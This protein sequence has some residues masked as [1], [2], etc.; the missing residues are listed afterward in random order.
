[1]VLLKDVEYL[2]LTYK[3]PE[4]VG[5][6]ALRY[7]QQQPVIIHLQSVGLYLLRVAE[8]R[9]VERVVVVVY[10][11]V[12]GVHTPLGLQQFHLRL[13]ALFP[14][15]LYYFLGR[16]VMTLNGGGRR[17]DGIHLRAQGVYIVGCD[18]APDAEQTVVAVAHGELNPYLPVREEVVYGLAEDEEQGARI[19]FQ[20]QRVGD[21]DKLHRL[22]GVYAIVQAH[23]L[24]VDLSR[25]RRQRHINVEHEENLAERAA[26][27]TFRGVS[28][29][30][31]SYLYCF[32]SISR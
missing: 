2:V 32:H 12:G 10:G 4:L 19:Y 23:Q 22:V 31:T 7:A 21:V 5:V 18:V 20:P 17:Y 25:H 3:L 16:S 29:V 6:A 24:I 30:L 15:Q 1:M 8:H 13:V 14:E 11:T 27:L 28:V 26:H 9:T